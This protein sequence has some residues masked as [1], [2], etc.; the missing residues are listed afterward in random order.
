M[1]GGEAAVS[2]LIKIHAVLFLQVEMGEVEMGVSLTMDKAPQHS[3]ILV[4][5]VVEQ[6]QL[7]LTP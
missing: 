4:V 7:H 1:E 5:V 6:R 2:T 3:P